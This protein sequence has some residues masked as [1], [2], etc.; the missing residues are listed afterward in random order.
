M[1]PFYKNIYAFCDY[2]IMLNK[3]HKCI[4]LSLIIPEIQTLYYKNP[5][6]EIDCLDKR[7][8]TGATEK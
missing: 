3:L 4:T 5:V 2:V 6:L 1:H 7:R 8:T